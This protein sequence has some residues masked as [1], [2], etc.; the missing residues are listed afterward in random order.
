MIHATVVYLMDGTVYHDVVAAEQMSVHVSDA[1]VATVRTPGQL[2]VYARCERIELDYEYQGPAFR[3]T[4]ENT[5]APPRPH[6]DAP[7]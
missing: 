6:R 4:R 5:M 1:R 2:I 3:F 7:F